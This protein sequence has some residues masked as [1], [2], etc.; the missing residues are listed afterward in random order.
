MKRNEGS[1]A[2]TVRSVIPLK[3]HPSFNSEMADESLYGMILKLVEYV[4]GGWYKAK[5]HYNYT[6]YVHE[7]MIHIDDVRAEEWQ[8]L[9]NCYITQFASDV[10]A[11]AKYTAYQL[12]VLTL[13]CFICV[14]GKKDGKWVE[15]ELIDNRKGWIREEHY[16]KIP[17][18]DLE[19][20]ERAIR[21]N[22]IDTAFLYMGTQYR[23]GGKSPLGIDCSGFVSMAYMLNGIIIYRDAQLKEEYMKE[24]NMEDIKPADLLFFP[25]HVAMYIGDGKYIHSTG[26]EG[27][28]L[29]NSLN[30][31]DEN[32]REDLRKDISAIGTVFGR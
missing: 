1:F 20:D 32:Y 21:K 22:I 15:I 18:L 11:E 19:N 2:I 26:R 5:T 16:K 13:G 30:P 3:L 9:A 7:S 14:T 23:W 12:E 29:V 17:A 31:N 4:G 8:T 28:V 24:I 27:R 6:G 25:G 10:M